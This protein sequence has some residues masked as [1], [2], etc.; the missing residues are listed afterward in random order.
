MIWD[1]DPVDD[2]LDYFMW[3]E[4]IDP[5]KEYECSNCGRLMDGSCVAWCE[6]EECLVCECPDCG[7][8]SKIC[9]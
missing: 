2:P 1:F 5:G 7:T 8:V 4:F 3:E 9:G 6:E